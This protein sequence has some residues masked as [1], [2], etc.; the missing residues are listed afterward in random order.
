MCINLV[1]IT[2]ARAFVALIPLNLMLHQRHFHWLFS[3]LYMWSSSQI[4][5]IELITSILPDW[6]GFILK[7]RWYLKGELPDGSAIS[8]NNL[9]NDDEYYWEVKFSEGDL[10]I[11]NKYYPKKNGPMKINYRYISIYWYIYICI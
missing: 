2:W 4:D 10:S 8:K 3:S 7:S 11:T 5:D 6:D 9:I 1:P